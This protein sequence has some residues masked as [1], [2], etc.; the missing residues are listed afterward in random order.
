[1]ERYSPTILKSL[2]IDI[3]MAAGV[4]H[5]DASILADSLVTADLAGTNTHGLSRLAI[6]VRRMQKGVID[7]KAKLTIERQR[8]ATLAVDAGNG[9]GQVQAW[10]TLERLIPMAK[11]AGVAS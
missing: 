4:A 3:A 9:L 10:R 5:D 8:A 11:S 2:A 7:A 6:Y 1:M